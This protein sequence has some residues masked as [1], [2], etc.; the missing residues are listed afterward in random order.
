MANGSLTPI[1]SLSHRSLSHRSLSPSLKCKIRK[2]L[3]PKW[4][5]RAQEPYIIDGAMYIEV[6]Q[7]D[8][9]EWSWKS[10]RRRTAGP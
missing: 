8:F 3:T 1:C 6:M 10:R 9:G 5:R 2:F 7:K 4:N